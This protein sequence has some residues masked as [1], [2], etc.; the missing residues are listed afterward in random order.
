MKCEQVNKLMG[1]KEVSDWC[2]AVD[3]VDYNYDLLKGE[4]EDTA[5]VLLLI[6]S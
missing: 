3:I 4:E 6:H 2:W 5:K 1:G